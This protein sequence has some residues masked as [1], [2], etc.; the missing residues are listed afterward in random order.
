MRGREVMNAVARGY[1]IE[2]AICIEFSGRLREKLQTRTYPGRRR[3][4][5][6]YR[7]SVWIDSDGFT[8]GKSFCDRN[9]DT[10]YAATNIQD[11]TTMFE[12]LDDMGSRLSHWQTK[13]CSY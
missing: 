5:P 11:P 4:C 2:A 12:A 10:A 13:R 7:V 1:Q 3:A 8:I 9:A 6:L